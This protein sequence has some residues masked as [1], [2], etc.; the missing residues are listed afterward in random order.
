MSLAPFVPGVNARMTKRNVSRFSFC[1]V[2]VPIATEYC[3][4]DDIS[5][6]FDVKERFYHSGSVSWGNNGGTYF[7]HTVDRA[8][9]AKI[10]ERFDNTHTRSSRSSRSRK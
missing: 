10:K 1:I 9:Y 4:V 7:V 2:Q 8:G 3:Q 5:A 6:I